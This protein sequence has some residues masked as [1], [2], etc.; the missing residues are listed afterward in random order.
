[1]LTL[2][3]PVDSPDA[4]AENPAETAKK[5]NLGLAL[6]VIACAQL[7]IVLDATVVNIALPHIQTDL[8]FSASGLQWV[9]TAYALALG[10][11]LLLGGRLG[12][13]FGRRKLFTI[14]I[15][16][17]AF[18]SC[19]AESRRTRRFSWRLACCRAPVRPWPSLPPSR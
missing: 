19:S 6:F 11:L 18:A 2:V 3:E 7:M 12:D 4:L 13:I 17:F 8:D 1:M 10:S 5:P 16:V 15:A 14:G 9:V